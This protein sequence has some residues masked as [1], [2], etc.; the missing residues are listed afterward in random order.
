MYLLRLRHWQAFLLLFILPF[1]LQYA[2]ASFVPSSAWPLLLLLN[3]LPTLVPT[4]WLW[5]LGSLFY[6][7]LPPSIKISAIYFHL[8]A[9]YFALYILVLI[10]TLGLVR[11]SMSEGFLPLGMV[12]LL[13]PIHLF[14]TFCYLFLVYFVA[15]SV[16]SV[17]KQRVVVTNEYILPLLQV[18][19][20]PI[21]IWFLQPR[22]NKLSSELAI[23]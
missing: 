20:M 15:R 9:L 23:H 14:A 6:Q 11:E 22:L 16:V 17:E 13:L 19:F 8:A 7:R 3:A 10:Y 4:L 1:A 21:G 2:L 18:M 12:A 5:W